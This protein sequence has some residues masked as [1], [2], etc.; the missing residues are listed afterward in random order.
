M[1]DVGRREG[2]ESERAEVMKYHFSMTYSRSL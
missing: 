2:G 1:E